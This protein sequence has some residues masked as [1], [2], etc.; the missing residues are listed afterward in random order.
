VN[1]GSEQPARIVK[2]PAEA[3]VLIQTQPE[4]LDQSTNVEDGS[5]YRAGAFITQHLPGV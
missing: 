3:I 5:R 2:P 1:A 4:F